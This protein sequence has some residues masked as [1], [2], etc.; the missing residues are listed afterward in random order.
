MEWDVPALAVLLVV[1]GVS[2]LYSIARE[3]A[4]LPILI[5]TV[6]FI[7]L[8]PVGYRTYKRTLPDN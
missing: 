2:S 8:L 7:L 4:E 6:A 3:S 5:A 1:T